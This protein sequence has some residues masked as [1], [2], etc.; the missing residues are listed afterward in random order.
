[1]DKQEH[2]PTA[3]EILC[4]MPEKEVDTV[5]RK[6]TIEEYLASPEFQRAR[7]IEREQQ[8][9]AAFQRQLAFRQAQAA[10]PIKGRP[11]KNRGRKRR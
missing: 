8:Q 10:N 11:R 1:M 9:L 3:E 4:R 5:P 7:K 6:V 2:I